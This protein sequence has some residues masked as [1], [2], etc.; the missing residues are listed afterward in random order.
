MADEWFVKLA[1][2]EQGPISPSQLRELVR[3]KVVKPDTFVRKGPNRWVR[4]SRVHGLFEAAQK[5]PASDP[6]P[7]GA[8]SPAEGTDTKPAKTSLKFPGLPWKKASKEPKARKPATGGETAGSSP[9]PFP[10]LGLSGGSSSQE[11][12]VWTGVTHEEA[13]SD[14]NAAPALDLGL[15]IEEPTS[16]RDSPRPPLPVPQ[17]DSGRPKP[18][19][20]PPEPPASSPPPEKTPDPEQPE[21]AQERVEEEP[22]TP[23][24]IRVE[25]PASLRDGPKM[26]VPAA[27][28]PSLPE[29]RGKAEPEGPE[30]RDRT[31]RKVYLGRES[32]ATAMGLVVYFQAILLLMFTGFWTARM[33]DSIKELEPGPELTAQQISILHEGSA[34]LGGT[35]ALF[36]MGAGLRFLTDWGRW[37]S[38][39]LMAQTVLGSMVTLLTL[40]L[41]GA[42]HLQPIAYVILVAGV[43]VPLWT[44][45]VT[46]SEPAEVVF[47]T[48]YRELIGRTRGVRRPVSWVAVVLFLLEVASLVYLGW[49]LYRA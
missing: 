41:L 18:T 10:E 20:P 47:S 23:L 19:T 5:A 34:L 39:T 2:T 9:L 22:A 40:A 24:G 48:A 14:P 38:A 31:T 46:L 17:P 29:A 27:V 32:S 36:L 33:L 49:N 30:S 28:E 21:A 42:S 11:S 3:K 6:S 25:E 8:P 16:L 1:G 12:Q 4:A 44:L 37:I 15:Q 35:A 26:P 13:D 45:Y 7:A 43:S